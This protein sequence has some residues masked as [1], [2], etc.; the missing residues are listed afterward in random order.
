MKHLLGEKIK[1]KK[2][3]YNDRVDQKDS[4]IKFINKYVKNKRILDI[5]CVQH[6]KENYK[7]KFWLHKAIK[8]IAS[9]VK[10]LDLYRDGVEYLNSKGFNVLHGDAQNFN[11]ESEYDVIVAG[12]IIEHLDNVQGFFKSCKR[13]LK[14]NGRLIITTPNPWYWK[15][16]ILAIVKKGNV[17]VNEEHTHWL[18]PSTLRQ[19]AERNGFEVETL[20]YGSRYDKYISKVLPEGIANT[21]FYTALKIKE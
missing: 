11:H 13:S 12:D 5:G 15:T 7:S 4:K 16:I 18:C 21:S 19:V 10:G 14:R 1:T 17:K 8:E 3:E 9:E 2:N 20:Q 6:N